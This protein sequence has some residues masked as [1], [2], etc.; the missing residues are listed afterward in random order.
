MRVRETQLSKE[1]IYSLFPDQEI[2]LLGFPS[3]R[4]KGGENKEA[5]LAFSEG[6]KT[7]L[8]DGGGR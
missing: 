5:L 2:L 4:H 3:V 6:K 1:A 7:K 8:E